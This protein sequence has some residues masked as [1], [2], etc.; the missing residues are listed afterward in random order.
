MYKTTITFEN[1]E[2][3]EITKTLYFRLTQAEVIDMEF[4]SPE[5]SVL[6]MLRKMSNEKN[7]R[8]IIPIVKRFMLDS[9][10]ERTDEGTLVKNK[11]IRD[12]FASSE[13]YSELFIKLISYVNVLADFVNNVIPKGQQK[14]IEQMKKYEKETIDEFIKTGD[15]TVFEKSSNVPVKVVEGAKNNAASTTNNDTSV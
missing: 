13:E 15:Y 4:N 2:G 8:I 3:E 7:M 6:N 10:C 12:K 1:S 5:G 9:Y 14:N 11:E